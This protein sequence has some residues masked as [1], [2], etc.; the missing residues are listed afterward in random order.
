M[1]ASA[2]ALWAGEVVKMASGTGCPRLRL[3]VE[4]GGVM[5]G[6]EDVQQIVVGDDGRVKGDLHGFGMTGEAGADLLIAG[7]GRWPPV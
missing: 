3:T 6:E 4:G 5:D 2:S 1:T 7:E